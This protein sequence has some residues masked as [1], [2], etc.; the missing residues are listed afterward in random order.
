MI[1]YK[2]CFQVRKIILR[3]DMHVILKKN[4]KKKYVF[5]TGINK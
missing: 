3:E 4:M 2:L 1:L 5:I